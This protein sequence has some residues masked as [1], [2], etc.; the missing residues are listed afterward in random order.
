MKCLL[1]DGS[2]S[3]QSTIKMKVD[4]PEESVSCNKEG[5]KIPHSPFSQGISSS[6]PVFGA[7]GKLGMST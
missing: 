6:R 7:G 4:A 2:Q 5:N 3:Q 1:Q